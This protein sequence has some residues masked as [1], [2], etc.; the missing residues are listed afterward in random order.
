MET[1]GQGAGQTRNHLGSAGALQK[2]SSRVPLV[3]GKR[4]SVGERDMHMSGA[5]KRMGLDGERE[6]E[7][8][9]GERER[10]TGAAQGIVGEGTGHLPLKEQRKKE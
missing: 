5:W 3:M 6:K 10:D 8:E 9:R 1:A 2:K 4:K 7:R